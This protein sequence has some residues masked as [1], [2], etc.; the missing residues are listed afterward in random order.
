MSVVTAE[1]IW[2]GVAAYLGAGFLVAVVV[3]L[4][5]ARATDHAAQGAGL[6]FRLIIMPAAMLLWPYMILRLLS[7]RKINAPVARDDGTAP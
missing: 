7:G 6:G 4:W 1:M 3:A 2:T 5:G